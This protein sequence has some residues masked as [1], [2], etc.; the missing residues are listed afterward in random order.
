MPFVKADI[1]AEQQK[2][3]KLIDSDSELKEFADELDIE[4]EFRQKL[5]LAR[6]KSGLTQKEL[7][8][9]SG[10][11]HRAISRAEN[12]ADISPNLKTLIKYIDALG[13][14]LDITPKQ[15]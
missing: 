3:Q 9:I 4:Y 13:F 11:D 10:L 6:K 2:V 1:Q 14:Q 7:S 5:I 15:M 8:K 12:N